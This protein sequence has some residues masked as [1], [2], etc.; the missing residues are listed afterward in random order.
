MRT[1][2]GN[3][4]HTKHLDGKQPH[5]PTKPLESTKT[6]SLPMSHPDLTKI[7]K[8]NKEYTGQGVTV[9]C[10]KRT[11]DQYVSSAKLVVNDDRWNMKMNVVFVMLLKVK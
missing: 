10:N 2:L 11:L 9:T 4:R 6:H 5:K 3:L 7:Y 1:N 8:E